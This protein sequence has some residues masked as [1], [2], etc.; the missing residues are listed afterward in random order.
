MAS[1][2]SKRKAIGTSSPGLNI[3]N[4]SNRLFI[5]EHL[6]SYTK[7]LLKNAKDTAKTK[8]FKYVWVREGCVYIRK[9]DT[10][11]VIRIS[12]L[13]DVNKL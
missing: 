11:R 6:T 12:S 9:D 2:K 7:K 8:F 13:D 4:V 1:A 3:E 5:N 10:A